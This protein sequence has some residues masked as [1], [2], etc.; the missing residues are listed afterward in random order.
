MNVFNGQQIYIKSGTFSGNYITDK[1]GL[2]WNQPSGSSIYDDT[3]IHITTPNN[4]SIDAP[5]TY[6]TGD[7]IYIN[8]KFTPTPPTFIQNGMHINMQ[9][10]GEWLITSDGGN[11]NALSFNCIDSTGTGVA[12]GYLTFLTNGT[13]IFYASDIRVK[14]NITDIEPSLEKLLKLKPSYFKYKNFDDSKREVSNENNDTLNGFIAQNVDE[15]FPSCVSD[16]GHPILHETVK[17]LCITSLI[18]YIVKS[19]QEQNILIKN[20]QK[21]IEDIKKAIS[22]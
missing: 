14:N 4:V 22:V 3:N 8:A 17:G 20:L 21:E 6:F 16:I 2:Y 10:G 15:F 13:G 19:I 12:G 11:P 9:N 1:P 5:T 18:P 7:N